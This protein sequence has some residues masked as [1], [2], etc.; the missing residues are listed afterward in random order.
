MSFF[1]F[2]KQAIAWSFAAMMLLI[3]TDVIVVQNFTEQ[4]TKRDFSLSNPILFILGF[5]VIALIALAGILCNKYLRKHTE[6][7]INRKSIAVCCVLLFVVQAYICYNIYFSTDWDCAIVTQN[8]SNIANGLP[9]DS[10][11]Y[12]IYPN[13]LFITYFYAL[14]LSVN[15]DLFSIVL[16]QCFFSAIVAYLVYSVALELVK[17]KLTALFA[18]L[19]Y[20]AYIGTSPWFS[21]PYS[22]A[23]GILFPIA[24]LRLWQLANRNKSVIKK[25]ALYACIGILS[26]LGYHI[27]PQIIIV[28]IAIVILQLIK[29]FFVNLKQRTW[30]EDAIKLGALALAF[31]LSTAAY[32]AFLSAQ[33]D[34]Q[35][36]PQREYG[37]SHFFMMGLNEERHGVWHEEDVAYSGSF[38]TAEERAK[39]NWEKAIQRIKDY[40]VDGMLEHLTKKTLVNYGDGSFAWGVEGTFFVEIPEEPNGS[41]SRWF[42][43]FVYAPW[44][45]DGAYAQP[46]RFEDFLTLSQLAWIITLTLATVSFRFLLKRKN[47]REG[48]ETAVMLL[49]LIGLTLFETLFE[50]RS[51]Y[52]FTYAPFFII[53]A[54]IGLFFILKALKAKGVLR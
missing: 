53:S 3:L 27:K 52:L 49:S 32:N 4:F 31:L 38:A 29:L 20:C 34:L 37:I 19:F 44:V 10:E 45:S 22:D 40:G 48:D 14:I 25:G 7:W 2:A 17:S 15:H 42:R 41:V 9:I 35:L 18:F 6:R 36:D 39:G 1:R 23:T 8:A 46:S 11:Y 54:S 16:V 51:R 47:E 26:F 50:P 43:S 30:R 13:N 24:I 5:G 12:S 33:K 21:I 28:L